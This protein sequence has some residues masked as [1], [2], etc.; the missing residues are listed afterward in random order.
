LRAS[1]GNREIRA[2]SLHFSDIPHNLRDCVIG[3]DNRRFTHHRVIAKRARS[4]QWLAPRFFSALHGQRGTIGMAVNIRNMS[5]SQLTDL[6]QRARARQDELARDKAARL[7]A[8]I[9]EMVKAEGF[10]IEDVFG[11]SATRRGAAKR[12]A[13]KRKV[14]PKYRNPADP[15]QTWSGRG[16]RPRWFSAA[17]DAGKKD[18]DLLIG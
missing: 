10:A 5:H 8:K 18:N 9:S 14:K 2:G 1:D 11:G 15:A 13:P 12:G 16:K 3:Y 17:L 7:R 6:I 4:I